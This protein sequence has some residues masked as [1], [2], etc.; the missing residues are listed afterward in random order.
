VASEQAD[1]GALDTAHAA[2]ADSVRALIGAFPD[3]E[4]PGLT[5]TPA[6]AAK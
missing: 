5:G 3:N 4:R 2:L 6:G 1:P